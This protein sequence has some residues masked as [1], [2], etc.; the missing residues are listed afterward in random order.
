MLTQ[1]ASLYYVFILADGDFF[2]FLFFSFV[3][4]NPFDF[5]QGDG[6]KR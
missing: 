5:A 1:E 2:S 4:I 3:M 6:N